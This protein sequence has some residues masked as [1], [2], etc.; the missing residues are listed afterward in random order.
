MERARD[1]FPDIFLALLPQFHCFK[2]TFPAGSFSVFL[3]DLMC[4]RPIPEGPC[5]HMTPPTPLPGP[6]QH[7]QHCW[8]PFHWSAP[9]QCLV[10]EDFY[11]TVFTVSRLIEVIIHYIN[12]LG[13]SIDVIFELLC[14][15]M[16]FIH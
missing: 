6:F 1:G 15:F 12:T 3:H 9:V 10:M 5:T 2:C 11:L 13:A 14:L 4:G 16:I 8:S 7:N